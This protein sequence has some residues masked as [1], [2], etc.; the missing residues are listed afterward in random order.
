[1][2]ESGLTL[3]YSSFG[4]LYHLNLF[5]SVISVISVG[6]SI[7]EFMYLEVWLTFLF[8]YFISETSIC[9]CYVCMF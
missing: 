5:I 4:H 9:L 3:D 6:V 7:G 8:G 2:H 1:M